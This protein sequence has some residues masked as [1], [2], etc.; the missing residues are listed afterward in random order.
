MRNNKVYSSITKTRY[1][2]IAS[3]AGIISSFLIWYKFLP[4]RKNTLLEHQTVLTNAIM[5]KVSDQGSCIFVTGSADHVTFFVYFWKSVIIR[6][7]LMEK[8]QHSSD[9]PSKTLFPNFFQRLPL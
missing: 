2:L 4:L 3:D 8:F 1:E 7:I 6:A 5:S 9:H